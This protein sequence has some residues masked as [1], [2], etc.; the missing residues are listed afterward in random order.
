MWKNDDV[1][2]RQDRKRSGH[3]AYMGG[4][5]AGRNSIRRHSRNIRA[6]RSL[7]PSNALQRNRHMNDPR[8]KISNGPNAEPLNETIAGTARGIP[9]DA[10][11]N[12][13]QLPDP[14]TDEQVERA[15]QALGVECGEVDTLPLTGE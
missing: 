8:E 5:R 9:D 4:A 13:E 15:K 2:E 7:N 3:A 1:A 11:E 12:G 10:L 6:A 14:P